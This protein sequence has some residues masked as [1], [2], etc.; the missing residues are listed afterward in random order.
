MAVQGDV[1]ETRSPQTFAQELRAIA[2][3]VLVHPTYSR[4]E[5]HLQQWVEQSCTWLMDSAREP[6]LN[7]KPQNPKTL[8]PKPKTLNPAALSCSG[9]WDTF[10]SCR[11]RRLKEW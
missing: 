6:T 11:P 2:S 7:P 9:R 4:E 5:L 8:N 1:A 10:L 3:R